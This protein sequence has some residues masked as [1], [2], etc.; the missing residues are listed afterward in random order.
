MKEAPEPASQQY[1][2]EQKENYG[3]VAFEVRVKHGANIGFFLLDIFYTFA[4]NSKFFTMESFAF[5]LGE[6]LEWTFGILTS[7]ENLPNNA[8]ILVMA[9][10]VLIWLR[11][12][13]QYNRE[14]EANGTLK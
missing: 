14:A 8:F 9:V 4:P 3:L 7:L 5:A 11:K 13:A 10:G 2:R 12:Q 1:K 6:I